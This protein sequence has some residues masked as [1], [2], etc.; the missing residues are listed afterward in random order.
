MTCPAKYLVLAS[1]ALIG[2]GGAALLVETGPASAQSQTAQPAQPPGPPAVSVI[3]AAVQRGAMP[4]EILAN[5]NAQSEATVTVRTRVD[6]QIQQRF[7][8]EGQFVKRGDPLFTLDTRLTRATL[9]QQ[10]AQL[11]AQKAVAARTAADVTR[12]ASLRGEGFAAQ[13][14]LEQAQADAAAAAANVR[15][16]EAMIDYTRTTLDYATITAEA[17]GRLGSLPVPVGNFVR[18]A[19]NTALATIT[20]M[21]PILVQ[22]AVPERWLPEIRAAMAKE[23][24]QVT[25]RAPTES[26]TPSK[27]QLVFI[28][29]Q[30]DSTTGTVMLKARFNNADNGLW[31]GEYVN[32][33]LTPSIEPDAIS[34]PVQAVQTGQQGRYIYTV[35]AEN[36]AHRRPVEMQRVVNGR[37]V[38][39]GEVKAGDKVVIEGTQLL[40]DGAR[41][42]ERGARPQS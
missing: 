25:A 42:V 16:T 17:S 6:G 7:V 33:V 11:A 31:P 22:F 41:V 1:C 29:S 9:A 14:R 36:R 35:D 13:Q 12:Y 18:A 21:D 20:Q 8:Q 4:V 27:G 32:V 34:V 23:A 39:T 2:L 40:S 15:A 24:P 30:V 10:E 5:G 28:D 19:D 37:A 38:I 26:R 3:T